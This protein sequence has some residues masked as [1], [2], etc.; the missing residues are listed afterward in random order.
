MA[1]FGASPR[2]G[3]FLQ[4][5]GLSKGMPDI[6]CWS[7]LALEKKPGIYFIRPPLCNLLVLRIEN[8]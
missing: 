1:L 4:P 7:S 6:V 5:A 2:P 3:A 8:H